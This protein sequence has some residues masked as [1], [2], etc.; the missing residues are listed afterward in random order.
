MISYTEAFDTSTSTGRMVFVML[1]AVAEKLREDICENTSNAMAHLRSIGRRTSKHPPYGFRHESCGTKT[2]SDKVIFICVPVPEE[3]TT[4]RVAHSLRM[5][6]ATLRDISNMLAYLG[7]LNRAQKP[8][9]P[10]VLA[11]ILRNAA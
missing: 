2:G 9:S 11:S 1:S 4:I 10:A 7:R 3:Q 5:P 8:F 6:G